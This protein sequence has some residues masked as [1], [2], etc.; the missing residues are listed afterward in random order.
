MN[1]ELISVGTEILLGDILNTNAQYLS[2]ELA[3]L[4]VGVTHQCTVGDNRERLL[5][6][7]DLAFSRCD[8]IIFTGGL[9]P[10]PDDL[11]KEVCSEYF[12]KELIPDEKTARDI[13]QYFKDRNREMPESNLKQAL[14]PEGANLLY[15]TCG[16]APGFI[17]EKEGKIMVIL[18]GPPN[19]MTAMFK[20][21]VKPYLKEKSDAVILS[22]NVRTFGIGESAMSE[23]V[24][25]LL[26]MENPTVAPYAKSGEALL[27]VTAKAE[28]EEKADL[29]MKDTIEEIKKRLGDY[30]YGIDVNSTEEA[31]SK[32]LKE[33]KLTVSFAESCTGGLCGKRMTDLSGASQIFHC[34]VI[35]YSNEIKE[36]VLSV[37]REHLEKYGA[38]SKIVAAEM[39]EGVRKLS[40]SSIGVSITGE[41]GPTSGDG[42][43]VGLIYVAVTDGNRVLIEELHGRAGG[44]NCRNYNRIYA[45]SSAFNAAR[46]FLEKGSAKRSESLKEFLNSY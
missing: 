35:S 42:K 8:M 31:L 41:A 2:R 20:N 26:D 25:D 16:T 32:A 34:G 6:A 13:E 43:P 36:K 11:T 23:K 4:G 29:L 1:C 44:D 9:G 45:A 46:V 15:N 37:K 3:S 38:V 24:R 22:H 27:R 14:V 19:E 17:M 18:P 33:K 7:I 39:A 12:K 40:S 21:S 10:T 30:I 5:S 28:S